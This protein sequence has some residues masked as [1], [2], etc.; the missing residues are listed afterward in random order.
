[1]KDAS[2]VS[3]YD[4]SA[5][6]NTIAVAAVYNSNQ[7]NRKVRPASSLLLFNFSGQL[8]RA[9]AL[10][11]S[12]AIARLAVDDESNIWTLTDH[13]DVNVNPSTVPMVVEYTAAGKILRELL[14]R[15]MFP[16]HAKDTKENLT[17]GP[18]AM[19]Y[20]AGVVW[21]WLPGSTDFV[22]I[23][24]R[25][26]K[27]AMMKTQLPKRAGR[28]VVPLGIARDTSGNVLAQ[29]REDDDQGRPEIKSDVENFQTLD[30]LEFPY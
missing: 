23:S 26:G 1:V 2:R 14:T 19:G 20:D 16:F 9:F 18:T 21:L 8:L 5:R 15:D 7:G 28:T 12:H 6:R 11:P 25:D 24:I 13:A 3:I 30:E 4:V 27:T 29:V 10:E 22:T 17:I